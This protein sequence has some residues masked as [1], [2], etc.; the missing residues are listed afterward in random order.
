M[1]E[2]E[3][4]DSMFRLLEEMTQS[5]IG[6]PKHA[7][8]PLIFLWGLQRCCWIGF[9]LT[10]FVLFWQRYGTTPPGF[11]DAQPVVVII[12]LVLFFGFFPIVAIGHFICYRCP[13]KQFVPYLT[14]SREDAQHRDAE[15][16][17]Q[18][19]TFDK[20]T[21]A[22]GLLQY[23][24]RWSS[25]DDRFAA[26]VGDLRKLGLLPALAVIF[27]SVAAL[28]EDSNQ[29]LWVGLVVIIVVFNL[30]A[31]AVFLSSQRRQQVIHLLE[32]AIQHADRCDKIP[33]SLPGRIQL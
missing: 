31:L 17:P 4:L 1:L 29:F 18:L 12:F 24:H 3:K 11:A 28:K 13:P 9:P 10:I 27:I 8:W 30:I 6:D 7:P 23:R 2:T 26:F 25:L 32:Y 20:A 21:L 16:I 22:Y 19:L 15:F 5:T 14:L 33:P